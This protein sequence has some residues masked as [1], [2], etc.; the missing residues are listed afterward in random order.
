M[1]DSLF[2]MLNR[3]KQNGVE[4][5]KVQPRKCPVSPAHCCGDEYCS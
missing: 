1:L 3:L 2:L 5:N 4:T